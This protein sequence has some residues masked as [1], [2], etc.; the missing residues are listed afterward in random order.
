MRPAAHT[1]AA[2]EG[3]AEAGAAIFFRHQD[4]EQPKG[5]GLLHQVTGEVAAMVDGFGAR[6]DFPLGELGN[7]LANLLLLR[8]EGELHLRLERSHGTQAPLA[9]A[10]GPEFTRP[11]V[12]SPCALPEQMPAAP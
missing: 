2:A 9:S 5:G 4:P 7:Q 3:A 8:A 11:M 1:R 6:L 12:A 10:G